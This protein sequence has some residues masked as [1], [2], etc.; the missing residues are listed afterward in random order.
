MKRIFVSFVVCLLSG[1]PNAA[2]AQECPTFPARG[3]EIIDGFLSQSRYLTLA[4]GN[5]DQR[6][7]LTKAI[8]EQMKYD[9]GNW[10]LK[11][12]DP[13][14]PQS[15]DSLSL[16][17]TGG[18]AFCNWDWQNGTTRLRS[19]DANTRGEF[20]ADQHL[21][22]TAAVNHLGS[23]V[24]PVDP[25]A[26]PGI[27]PALAAALVRLDVLTA[28][29]VALNVELRQAQEAFAAQTQAFSAQSERLTTVEA[30]ISRIDAFLASRAVPTDCRASFLGIPVSCRLE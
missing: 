11:S 27:D 15:K 13:G 10:S 6:R 28:H 25:P 17:V 2:S 14:R 8:A 4:Q 5:D 20:I 24:A 22:P 16:P 7:E 3:V 18:P 30:S 23:I 29:V 26:V 9:L 1:M 19:I 21:L 12:A